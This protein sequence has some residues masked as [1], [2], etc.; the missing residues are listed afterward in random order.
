M[1]L[2]RVSC[3]DRLPVLERLGQLLPVDLDPLPLDRHQAAHR[4]Q[5]PFQLGLRERLAVERQPLTEIRASNPR[6]ARS[7]YARRP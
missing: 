1:P 3:L 6:L 5:E 2:A 4:L 7:L